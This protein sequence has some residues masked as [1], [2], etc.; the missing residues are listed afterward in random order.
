ML[1]SDKIIEF[2]KFSMTRDDCNH[3]VLNAIQIIKSL[4][5]LHVYHAGEADDESLI[6]RVDSRIC[7][8]LSLYDFI[9]EEG[10]SE[11]LNLKSCILYLIQSLQLQLEDLKINMTYQVEDIYCT[12]DFIVP[13]GIVIHEIITNSMNHA[14]PV[15]FNSLA[16]IDITIKKDRNN[17]CHCTIIDNG[18]GIAPE[19]LTQSNKIGL[20]L[21]K[22]IVQDQLQGKIEIYS[23]P[24]TKVFLC[25]PFSIITE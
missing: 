22:K 15:L 21:A 3:Y 5:N 6:E 2:K 9:C 19:E 18:I 7:T 10:R 17:V 1:E 23:N 16:K 24:G 14:F 25:I 4:I 11:N 20:F 12:Q 8:L 13:F